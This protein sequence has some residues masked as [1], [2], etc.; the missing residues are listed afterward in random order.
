METPRKANYQ[1]LLAALALLAV[2]TCGKPVGEEP[3]PAGPDPTEDATDDEASVDDDDEFAVLPDTDCDAYAD[4]VYAEWAESIS[5]T[6]T[7]SG[8][9]DLIPLNAKTAAKP[10]CEAMK[11]ADTVEAGEE[12]EALCQQNCEACAKAVKRIVDE[13]VHDPILAAKPGHLDDYPESSAQRA[14]EQC[15]AELES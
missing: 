9:I 3:V 12:L 13:L 14:L 6:N 4:R 11:L 1:V 15:K 10:Y 5:W 7:T 8:T 2:G